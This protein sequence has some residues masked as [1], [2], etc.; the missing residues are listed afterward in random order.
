MAVVASLNILMKADVG[1][2]TRGID[3]FAKRYKRMGDDMKRIG[4]DITESVMTPLERLRSEQEKLREVYNKG[5]ITTQTYGR[6]LKELQKEYDDIAKSAREAASASDSFSKSQGGFSLLTGREGGG[7]V[8]KDITK[9]LFGKSFIKGGIAGFLTSALMPKLS[10]AIED[11]VTSGLDSIIGTITGTSGL[12]GAMDR[13][14]VGWGSYNAALDK[15]AKDFAVVAAM[16]QRG[17]QALENLTKQSREWE[18]TKKELFKSTG[19]SSEVEQ[20][21]RL[22]EAF[23]KERDRLTKEREQ[24]L[25]G[26]VSMFEDP[27]TGI[28]YNKASQMFHDA[29]DENQRMVRGLNKKIQMIT[30]DIDK[31]FARQ[32]KDRARA[33]R[34]ESERQLRGFGLTDTER[35]VQ[36]LE[37]QLARVA[38]LEAAAVAK[39]K[40]RFTASN[41]DLGA[42][43]IRQQIQNIKHLEALEREKKIKDA[44]K[45]LENARLQ[46]EQDRYAVI[47]K[48]F[49]A[50][51]ATT[52]EME[53]ARQIVEATRKAD[54]RK[55]KE[56]K[57]QREQERV[58]QKRQDTARSLIESA[59]S[60]LE[61]YQKAIA[62]IE[63]LRGMPGITEDILANAKF[64]ELKKLQS[65]LESSDPNRRARTVEFGTSEAYRRQLDR[66]SPQLKTEKEILAEAKKQTDIQ[67]QQLQHFQQT[68]EVVF[69]IP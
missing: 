53:K 9:G 12:S 30:G 45:Q 54:E 47:L 10:S 60:P 55:A 38:Q 49:E 57:A 26:G 31:V 66:D 16:Q 41:V 62:D 6:A 43:D 68:G 64:E 5:Y 23:T 7:G 44:L 1:H 61:R 36:E 51:G 8:A 14:R 13:I 11:T 24:I 32:M 3:N 40:D 35:T 58:E 63:S 25:K 17:R 59:M 52:A 46:V 69:S 4:R 37:K 18:A 28:D 22:R 21:V 65:T 48:E 56:E 15:H 20:G 2:A 50:L 39:A 67:R 29:L 19:M 34:L 27:L 33:G 42:A